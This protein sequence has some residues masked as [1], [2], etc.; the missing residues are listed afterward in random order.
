MNAGETMTYKFENPGDVPVTVSWEPPVGAPETRTTMVRVRSASFNGNP[1][2]YVR[3]RR[4]WSNPNIADNIHVEADRNIE[5]VDQGIRDGARVFTLKGDSLGYGY[6]TARLYVGG[7]II[8]TAIMRVIDATTHV[9]DGYHNILTDFGDGTALYDGYVVV[10]HVEPGM[11]IYVTLWGSNT[12]FE[13]G[14]REKWFNA[15]QFNANG[16]LHYSII[17]GSNFT[18][19]QSVYL[20]QNGVFIKQLQ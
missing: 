20:Y 3:T 14:T 4:D 8:S 5:F 1:I 9:N 7:P 12:L 19:C 11:Q 18:T 15:S 13:D 6:V 16:E 10:D 17:G 2:C